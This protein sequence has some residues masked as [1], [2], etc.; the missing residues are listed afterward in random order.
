[1]QNT[2]PSFLPPIPKGYV[3][4]GA[5]GTFKTPYYEFKG[6]FIAE[7]SAHR[8]KTWNMSD[9]CCPQNKKIHYIAPENSKIAQNNIISIDI[10]ARSTEINISQLVKDVLLAESLIGKTVRIKSGGTAKIERFKVMYVSSL[11]NRY[12]IYL[13]GKGDNLY[14]LDTVE[15]IKG[16]II[17]GYTA[18]LCDDNRNYQFV[19]EAVHS[20]RLLFSVESLKSA[21]DFLQKFNGKNS[22]TLDDMIFT[23][24]DLEKLELGLTFQD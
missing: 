6:G 8:G 11:P 23:L 2:P 21:R 13:Y 16:V 22:V 14:A 18:S 15:E 9:A 19:K 24:A 20:K 4:L 17:N 12:L 1:M 3:Y 10:P 7:I 5:S